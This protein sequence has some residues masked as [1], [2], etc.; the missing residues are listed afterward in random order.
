MQKYNESILGVFHEAPKSSGANGLEEVDNVLSDEPSPL[1]VEALEEQWEETISIEESW[2]KAED[3]ERERDT[4]TKGTEVLDDPVQMYLQEIGQVPLLTFSQEQALARKLD[5]GDH[6]EALEQELAGREGQPPQP[7]EITVALLRRLVAAMPLMAVLGEQLHLPHN[8]TLLQ[9]TN[10]PTLRAQAT[11]GHRRWIEP[12][13][14]GPGVR[15][16]G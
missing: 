13:V 14:D 9:I 12:G 10:H 8:L 6:L 16:A 4:Q 1:Q 11:G 15:S 5:V 2:A 3:D 7:W